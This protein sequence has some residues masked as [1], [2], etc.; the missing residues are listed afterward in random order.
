MIPPG[1]AMLS[2]RAA[3]LTPSPKISSPSTITSPRLTP[4]RNW[5]R[6][7]PGPGQAATENYH[8]YIIA[9]FDTAA[10][11]CF[12]QSDGDSRGRRVSVLVQ[13]HVK[14]LE[15]N[16]QSVGD[17]FDDAQVGLMWNDA[18]DVVRCQARVRQNFS[19]SV[20]HRDD[21]LFVSFLP[22]HVNRR[23]IHSD[24][25]ERDWAARAAARH[26]QNIGEL[27]VTADM[28]ADNAVRATPMLQHRRA[29]AVAE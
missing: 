12:V 10:A 3:T 16:F 1:L 6:R 27:T 2:N 28:R 29:G 20:D 22:G 11:I 19:G 9:M 5:M 17:G 15:R 18:G 8:Q 14:S 21:G 25:V 13:I 24:I 4:M 26:K 7:S 23:Q